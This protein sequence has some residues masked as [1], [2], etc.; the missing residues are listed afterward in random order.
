MRFGILDSKTNE[1]IYSGYSGFSG[2]LTW[3]EFHHFLQNLFYATLC[4]NVPQMI[5]PRTSWTRIFFFRQFYQNWYLMIIVTKTKSNSIKNHKLK[6]ELN[7]EYHKMNEIKKRLSKLLISFPNNRQRSIFYN[8]IFHLL[9]WVQST[10][11]AKI[12]K[13]SQNL[14]NVYYFLRRFC[15]DFIWFI[16]WIFH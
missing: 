14:Y 10:V 16:L 13:R 6:Y 3:W 8:K 4:Q 5:V 7:S 15:I 12:S 11:H 2:N 9:I 1:K